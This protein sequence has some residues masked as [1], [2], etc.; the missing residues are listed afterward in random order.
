MTIEMR[1]FIPANDLEGYGTYDRHTASERG[2]MFYQDD[3]YLGSFLRRAN[4][5]DS[6]KEHDSYQSEGFRLMLWTGSKTKGVKIFDQDILIG[7]D[8]KPM[9][10]EW[11]FNRW[12]YRVGRRIQEFNVLDFEANWFTI[13]GNR[14]QNPELLEGGKL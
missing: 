13:I 12:V 10:V 7:V 11:H 6:G 3:Q 2:L 5:M 8:K 9:L 4:Y 14:L 1:A